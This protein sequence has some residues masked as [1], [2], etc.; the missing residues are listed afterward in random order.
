MIFFRKPGK[1]PRWALI[2][3]LAVLCPVLTAGRVFETERGIYYVENRPGQ[4][5][6]TFDTL[7]SSRGLT[8]ILEVLGQEGVKATFFVSGTWLRLNP[9]EA[10]KILLAGHEIGNRTVS[11]RPLLYLDENSLVREISDFNHLSRQMLE[12]RPRLFRPP[13]GEYSGLVQRVARQEDCSLVLWTVESYDW[14]SEDC[15]ELSRR[16]LEKARGGAIISFRVGVPALAGA[17]PEII[18]SLRDEGY[19]LVTVSRLLP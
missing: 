16:V 10:R 12:Y 6:F 2:T 1:L 7:W 4:V 3:V 9:E 15:A 13:Q 19:E 11:N 14:L 5:A 17:L 8:Q 18:A